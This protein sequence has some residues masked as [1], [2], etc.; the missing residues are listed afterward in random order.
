MS[1]KR[2]LHG[3]LTS[4]IIFILVIV[5]GFFGI[6]MYFR[7]N[8][9]EQVEYSKKD[10]ARFYEKANIKEENYEFDMMDLF[11]GNIVAT[12][13]VDVDASF[14][15]EELTAFL[16]GHSDDVVSLYYQF[17]S[18]NVN[19]YLMVTPK[20]ARRRRDFEDSALTDFNVRILE[21]DRLEVFAYVN[22]DISGIYDVIEGLDSYSLIVDRAAGACVHLILDITFKKER[23]FDVEIVKLRINGIPVP[24]GFIDEY[25]PQLTDLLNGAID[26]V[27][28]FVVDEFEIDDDEIIFKGKLPEY[29]QRLDD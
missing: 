18:L 7:S 11:T 2:R 22:E 16:Q 1:G 15:S 5:V 27:D 4:F 29:I 3:C 13:T 28:Y 9:P 14:D 8:I 19:N 26:Q 21:D 12:G 24:N 6:R 17:A 10:A 20:V 23:G 25:E